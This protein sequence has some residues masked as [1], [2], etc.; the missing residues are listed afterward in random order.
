MGHISVLRAIFFWGVGCLMILVGFAAMASGTEAAA[1]GLILV[2]GGFALIIVNKFVF[3][4]RK[5]Q[6]DIDAAESIKRLEKQ[7]EDLKKEK[8]NSE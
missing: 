4:V 7:V 8:S 2:G 3:R 6:L 5:T 1:N